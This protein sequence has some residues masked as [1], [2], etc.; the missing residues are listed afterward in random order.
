ML[1]FEMHA[2]TAE[3]SDCGKIPAAHEVALYHQKGYD[4]II[5]TDHYFK[6][7]FQEIADLP[8]PEQ[9]N[10]YLAGYR[11]AKAEG[12][13]LGLTVLWGLEL[14][15]DDANGCVNDFLVYGPTEQDLLDNPHLNR[16]TPATFSPLAR[17]KGWLFCQAHPFR[18]PAYRPQ[19]PYYMEDP[20]LLD[21]ME[22]Y[23]GH[24]NQPS[25]NPQAMAFHKQHP[26]LIPLAGS[27]VHFESGAGRA[28]VL[29]DGPV[30][31]IQD[32]IRQ[33]RAR[34]HTLWVTTSQQ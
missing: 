19:A 23:N 2:H 14:R 17:Q 8:W 32:I 26:E 34:T 9:V 31:S 22:V 21:G 13:K 12:D 27:D 30:D 24:P 1:R 15:F 29:F 6:S 4:G 10:R 25:H 20:S 7:F 33:L 5:I 3:T 18:F 16:M 28:A 11:A